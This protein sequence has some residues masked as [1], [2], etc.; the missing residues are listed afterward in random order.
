MPLHHLGG[1]VSEKLASRVGHLSS[2]NLTEKK[3]TT[4]DVP[5]GNLTRRCQHVC[6]MREEIEDAPLVRFLSCLK[7]LLRH[8][9]GGA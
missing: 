4:E 5:G 8:R 2:V 7:S 1:R 3:P 9:D 6:K